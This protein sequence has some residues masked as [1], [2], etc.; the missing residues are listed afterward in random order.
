MEGISLEKDSIGKLLF[1]FSIPAVVGM[2]VNALYGAVDT[3][4]VG[5]FVGTNAL[6]GV[7]VTF[8]ITNTIM[9]VGMLVGIGAAARI[10]ISL[11]QKKKYR[12]EKYLGNAVVLMIIGYAFVGI[13]GKV[14]IYGILSYLELQPEVAE[15]A[16]TFT[17]IMLIGSIFQIM[18][19]GLNN[20][21]RSCGSP[22]IAMFTMIIG[23]I[24]NII[25]DYIFIVP[26][27]MGVSGAA[28]ATI[29]AQAVSCIWVTAYF[30]GK[31]SL[32]KMKLKNFKLSLNIV[33]LI[34]SIGFAPFML[35][36]A[37]S[38]IQF[39]LS[40]QIVYAY[41]S[42]E[43]DLVIGVMAVISRLTIIL[44]MPVFGVN[45]G[46]QPIIGYNY[47]AK[48]YDRVKKTLKLAM[49]VSTI[50]CVSSFIMLETMPKTL[51]GLFISKN[52]TK[53]LEIGVH[54]IRIY[55]LGFAVVG[56]QVISSSFFQSIGKAAI[57]MVLSMSRQIIL[58]IPF[59]LILPRFFGPEG[60][61]ISAPMSDGL[62]FMISMFM[63]KWE[64]NKLKKEEESLLLQQSI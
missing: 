15:Y 53:A 39:I 27:K 36:M 11:G 59:L 4:F 33:L 21:I 29:I 13:I 3:I 30:F 38:L 40:R 5:Q 48:K 18:G 50:L 64:M 58:L 49:I 35:Q 26:F 41:N 1:K 42:G 60:I 44:L 45:Q 37:G 61:W 47:G 57:S 20:I 7:G 8:P 56:F 34:L 32:L 43:S 63:I 23:G 24:T 6:A 10:S 46:A 22:K 55:C 62:A 2:L 51:L 54:A 31:S 19:L 28:W 14:M 16:R 12:A 17:D 9:A 52:D 25:L